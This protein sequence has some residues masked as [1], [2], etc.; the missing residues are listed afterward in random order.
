MRF[1]RLHLGVH[2]PLDV[3]AGYLVAALWIGSVEIVLWGTRTAAKR[4]PP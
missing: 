2:Y 3:L 4:R 1:S